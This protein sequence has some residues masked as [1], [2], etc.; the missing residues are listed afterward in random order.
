M[1]KQVT[2]FV[3]T[4]CR[5]STSLSSS[6]ALLAATAWTTWPSSFLLRLCLARLHGGCRLRWLSTWR[7]DP[8]FN[9]IAVTIAAIED[10]DSP[11]IDSTLRHQILRRASNQHI[12]LTGTAR[13]SG[14][15]DDV[16][17]CVRRVLQLNRQII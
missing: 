7:T 3:V 13:T 8:D 11:R 1:K 9:E 4:C 12:R 14:I 5:D 6:D 15:D 10:G 2:T 17:L 16:S